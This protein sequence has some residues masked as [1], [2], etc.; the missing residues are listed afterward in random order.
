MAVALIVVE[1]YHEI[2]VVFGKGAHDLQ[3]VEIFVVFEALFVLRRVTALS[4]MHF[5]QNLIDVIEVVDGKV[6]EA[7]P[8]SALCVHLN[9]D[10]LSFQTQVINHVLQ[11]AHLM[12]LVSLL[13]FSQTGEMILVFAAV[14][15]TLRLLRV[16]AVELIVGHVVDRAEGTAEVIVVHNAEVHQRHHVL[17]EV[18]AEKVASVV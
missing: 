12:V 9:D 16:G 8:L 1:V 7:C 10:V 11:R 18:L 13:T 2:N 17:Q 15:R 5:Q 3:I 4:L 14:G 6:A